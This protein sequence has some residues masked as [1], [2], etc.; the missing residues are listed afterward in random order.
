MKIAVLAAA[1]SLT[2]PAAA[3]AQSST[4][5]ADAY[6]Q[7]LLGHHL[8]DGDDIDGAITAY[9]KAMDLDPSASEIPAEL[10]A[11]YL[12]QNKVQ[13]AMT[14]A[15]QALKIEPDNAEAN[16]VLGI[17][18]AALGPARVKGRQTVCVSNL[19][20]IWK[21]ITMYRSYYDWAEYTGG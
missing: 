6:A 7:F 8:E 14:A 5:A 11:L 4:R 12:R 16:R 13:D 21:A 10:A 9:K 19:H 17:V 3:A 15:E 18:Y 2:I 20:Q 1:L